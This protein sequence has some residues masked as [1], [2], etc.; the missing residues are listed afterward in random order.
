MGSHRVTCHPTEAASLNR[1]MQHGRQCK[2]ATYIDVGGLGDVRYSWVGRPRDT[3]EN[4]VVFSQ[5]R[6]ALGSANDPDPRRLIV[7][8]AQQQRP[9]VVRPHLP[10]PLTM[11]SKSLHTIPNT[12]QSPLQA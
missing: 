2:E 4:V 8:T 7:A 11:T 10:N 5:L 3:L 12:T 9:V 6:L 1:G